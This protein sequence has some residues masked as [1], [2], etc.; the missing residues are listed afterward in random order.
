M[1]VRPVMVVEDNGDDEEFMLLALAREGYRNVCVARDGAEAVA[2]LC[3]PRDA[4]ARVPQLI[5]LDLKLPKLDGFEVLTRIRAHSATRHIPVVV[6]ST[7]KLQPDIARCYALG[8]NSYV[9]KPV[10]IETL[11][12]TIHLITQYWLKLNTDTETSW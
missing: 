1:S 11:N 6:M 12:A 2:I 8:A 4:R 9:Q 5:L 7:S 3:D 10:S